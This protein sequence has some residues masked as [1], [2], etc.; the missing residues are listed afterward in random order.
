M[1]E[2]KESL[3]ERRMRYIERQRKLG[4]GVNVWFE[5]IK[6]EGSGPPNHH[7]LP[8]LPIGQHE[9]HN[10]PVLDL[11]DVPNI[12]LTDWRS[13]ARRPRRESGHAHMGRLPALPQVEDVSDFIAS[14]RGAA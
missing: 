7:G 14:R 5:G 1:A 13:R 12:S 10:W 11:G 3:V 2:Q 9:V 6:P 4:H 8:A